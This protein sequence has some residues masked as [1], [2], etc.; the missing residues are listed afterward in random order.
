M[1]TQYSITGDITQASDFK[2][3]IGSFSK[4]AVLSRNEHERKYN[5]DSS[6]ELNAIKS[7]NV[8]KDFV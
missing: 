6:Y 5:T 3:F 2:I 8:L 7:R 1:T 4:L